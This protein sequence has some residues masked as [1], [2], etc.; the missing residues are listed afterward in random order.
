MAQYCNS[1]KLEHNWLLWLMAVQTPELE[2]FRKLGVLWS[3]P[4]EYVQNGSC[5]YPNPTSKRWLHCIAVGH[6]FYFASELSILCHDH[7][8]TANIYGLIPQLAWLELDSIHE[9]L[10]LE[11]PFF[12]EYCLIPELIKSNYIIEQPTAESWDNMITDVNNTCIGVARKFLMAEEDR[13]DL[14]QEAIA[15]II[16]KLRH[17]KLIYQPGKAPVF[18]LLTTTIHRCMF[19][20]LNKGSRVK[21]ST[22]QLAID[23]KTGAVPQQFR[24]FRVPTTY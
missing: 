20:I 19:S 10:W 13:H 24:S 9:C 6:P 18:N 1:D 7:D 23:I 2:P 14:V 17:G 21:K 3:K 16:R 4:V 22:N 8:K 5:K 15:Q 11:E 12:V